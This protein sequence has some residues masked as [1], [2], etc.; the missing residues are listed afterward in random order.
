MARTLVLASVLLAGTALFAGQG[1]FGWSADVCRKLEVA[2]AGTYR[3]KLKSSHGGK[4]QVMHLDNSEQVV[5]TLA[6]PGDFVDISKAAS[7]TWW[8]GFLRDE[9]NLDPR[10][11]SLGIDLDLE[12][13][14]TA[15]KVKMPFHVSCPTSEPQVLVKIKKKAFDAKLVGGGNT[16]FIRAPFAIQEATR[17]Q[18]VLIK[19]GD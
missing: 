17:A 13:S 12:V 7:P 15:G 19:L 18:D 8:V 2:G 11:Q 10:W 16:T 6:E 3:L 9:G 1:P 14:D 5:E 4:L